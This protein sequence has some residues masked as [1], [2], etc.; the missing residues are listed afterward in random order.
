MT[1][2]ELRQLWV[3][4]LRSGEFKQGKAV[5]RST[6]NEYCCLGVLCEVAAR[7]G[8][9]PAGIQL[10]ECYSYSGETKWLAPHVAELVGLNNVCGG[11]DMS[12]RALTTMNDQGMSFDAIANF[13]ASEPEGLFHDVTEGSQAAL[14]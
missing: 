10:G 4:A 6:D 9:M 12:S 7:Q 3:N 2:K 8:L 13:I 11:I 5:L 1:P 14:G